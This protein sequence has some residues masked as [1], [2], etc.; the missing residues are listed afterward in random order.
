MLSALDEGMGDTV[1][2]LKSN[3]LWE[4]TLLVAH[5]DNGGELPF[6][7]GGEPGVPNENGGA[8]TTSLCEVANL[9]CGKGV[10][11]AMHSLVEAH[12]RLT[13]AEEKHTTV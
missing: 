2:S 12:Y 4:T 1:A 10:F 3:G 8:G 13:I 11:V 6:A 9:L 5:T 7:S